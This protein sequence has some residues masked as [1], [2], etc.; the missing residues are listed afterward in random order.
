MSPRTPADA[1]LTASLTAFIA[2]QEPASS[3]CETPISSASPAISIDQQQNAGP[4][5]VLGKGIPSN[6]QE[7]SINHLQSSG[8]SSS[9]EDQLREKITKLEDE[10]RQFK[11]KQDPSREIVKH[12][13]LQEE[14]AQLREKNLN[15]RV[16]LQIAHDEHQSVRRG[17]FEIKKRMEKAMKKATRYLSMGLDLSEGD[18]ASPGQS[19]EG[20]IPA[21]S[22]PPKQSVGNPKVEKTSG[23]PSALSTGVTGSTGGGLPVQAS[24]FDHDPVNDISACFVGPLIVNKPIPC[25]FGDPEPT[26]QPEGQKHFFLVSTPGSCNDQEQSFEE[27]R[28]RHY[29]LCNGKIVPSRTPKWL[30][31]S[32]KS[33]PPT[34]HESFDGASLSEGPFQQSKKGEIGEEGGDRKGQSLGNM[35]TAGANSGDPFK[36]AK[37]EG[38]TT[39]SVTSPSSNNGKTSTASPHQSVGFR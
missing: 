38:D 33:K 32:G 3:A 16:D 29:E 8:P 26:I 9:V 37:H 22:L 24:I 13:L 19:T 35:D 25:Y 23:T 15:L 11:L 34:P 5:S 7:P 28:L 10:I 30:D 17:Y 6:L 31:L 39:A 27:A 12:T 20:A 1:K 4:S 36:P 14:L 21:A 18:S 2:L